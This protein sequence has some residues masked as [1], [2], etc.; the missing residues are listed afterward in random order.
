MGE[1]PKKAYMSDE[2][3]AELSESFE[4]SLAYERCARE[5]YRVIHVAVPQSPQPGNQ[6][7]ATRE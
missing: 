7:K 2:T 4:Q 1:R 6:K 5:R 3:F